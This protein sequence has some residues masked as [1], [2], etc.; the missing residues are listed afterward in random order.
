[1]KTC[2]LCKLTYPADRTYCFVDNSDLIDLK[3]TRLGSVLAGRYLLQYT[4]GQGGMATVYGARHQLVD[5]TCAIKIMSPMFA[6]DAVVRERFR[7]EARAAQKLTH[8]N[9]IEIFDHGETDDG[10][11]YIVMEQLV[12]SSLA[13]IIHLGPMDIDR[14]VGLMIQMARGIARAHDLDVIHRD[15]KPENIFICK[16][17]GGRELVKLLDFGIARSLHDTRLTGQGELFGT[18]QYMAPERI[19]TLDA[20]PPADLYALGIIFFEMVT[21]ELPF[22]SED[23]AS[24]FVKHLKE[25]PMPPSRRNPLVPEELETL[26]LAL[27]AKDPNARPVDAHRVH[28]D[29]VALAR[30]RGYAIPPDP[31]LDPSSSSRR[32]PSTLTPVEGGRWKHKTDVFRRMM[33]SAY[34]LAPPI[35]HKQLLEEMTSIVT[36][37]AT[38]QEKCIA[39][40]EELEAMSERWR[41]VRQRFGFAVD[42]LGVD[43]SKAKQDE[44]ALAEQLA[45][46]KRDAESAAKRFL[47]SHREVASWEGRSG[48]QFPYAE[49]AEAYRNA[50]DEMDAWLAEKKNE[51][52]LVALMETAARATSD[53]EFQIQELRSALTKHEREASAEQDECAKRITD[54][55]KETDSLETRLSELATRFCEP[56]QDRADLKPFFR[57]LE[58][59]AAA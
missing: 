21:G 13:E 46:A 52:D 50:A 43:A 59:S 35:E 31:L 5:R 10:T 26:I 56:L 37:R 17:E 44:R 53:I 29:L 27:L 57:E 15:L 11:S 9:I 33:D 39:A 8:P 40:Q 58:E 7:R 19:S 12:G 55:T 54:A 38:L 14:A 45:M 25:T 30:A 3:D 22:Y 16:R 2:P 32:A 28:Q 20:G 41:D 48:F 51:D 36:R 1:M 24:F 6:R 49:L 42:A 34:G 18:P 47:Q 23:I 4:L